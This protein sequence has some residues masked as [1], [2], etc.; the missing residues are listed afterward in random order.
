MGYADRY[1]HTRQVRAYYDQNTKRFLRW[2]KD[3]GTF[4]IHGA[5]WP[6]EVRSL[7]EAMNYANELVA[8]EIERCPN[9]VTRVLDLGC[10]VGSTLFYLGRRLPQV[11]RLLGISLSPVQIRLARRRIPENQTHRF[12][13]EKGCFLELS[14]ARFQA[15]FA[16]AIEAFTHGPDSDR[17]FEVQAQMLPAGGRLALIDDWLTAEMPPAGEVA[18]HV[19]LLDRYRRN[20]L[21]PGLRS[22]NALRSSA[23]PQG[24]R[25]IR[26]RNLTP[27]LRLGR[28]RDRAI[29]LLVRW[30]GR[31]M[32]RN[33][34]LR[35]LVGGDAKQK[36][37]R[38]G[39]TAYRL[40]V[41]EKQTCG[42]A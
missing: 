6:P 34:Y 1:R 24:F 28:P 15:D 36:C 40:L 20:W 9:P 13:F 32:E 38:E 12:L 35:T 21:L 16:Y 23:A 26:D 14:V 22:V 8:R 31:L 3:E 42:G 33:A 11:R 4:N 39:L 7:G 2:G 29:A 18:R 17:F 19:K 5:L 10:G 41:F 30:T 37:Y 25:L 27:H